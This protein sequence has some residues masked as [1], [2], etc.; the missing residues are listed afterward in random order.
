M[1]QI[2]SRKHNGLRKKLRT[3]FYNI[4]LTIGPALEME[5]KGGF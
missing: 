3:W 5:G 2:P 4:T 1:R